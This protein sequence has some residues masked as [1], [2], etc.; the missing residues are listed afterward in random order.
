MKASRWTSMAGVLLVCTSSTLAAPRQDGTLRPGQ[1][2]QARVWIENRGPGEAVPVAIQ[3]PGS[4]A[5]PLRVQV[6][7]AAGTTITGVV[8]TRTVRQWWE[9]RT[10]SIP[11]GQDATPLLNAAGTD[12]WEM[13][14]VF[15]TTR[16]GTDI[17]F[18]RAQ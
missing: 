17:I 11:I 6:I 18:K 7:G 1:P 4:D 9:Y 3:P 8:Q 12:G 15:I 13:T 10:V 5:P 2:T 16:N 14:G